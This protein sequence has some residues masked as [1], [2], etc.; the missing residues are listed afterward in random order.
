MIFVLFF[1]FNF[2]FNFVFIFIFKKYGNCPIL[3]LSDNTYF[4]YL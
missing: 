4:H 1:I 3:S 2:N